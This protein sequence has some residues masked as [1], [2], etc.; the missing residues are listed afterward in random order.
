MPNINLSKDQYKVL[1]KMSEISSS[2]Y[3]ILGD[4]VSDN[5]KKQS[6]EIEK[7]NEY[8]LENAKNF[9]CEKFAEKYKGKY[10]PSDPFSKKIDSAIFE[11]DNETF[12]NELEIRLGK[13][14][15]EQSISSQ[16]AKEMKNNNGWY[17]ER[18]HLIYDKW[19]KEFEDYGI[20]RLDVVKNEK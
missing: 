17:P 9:G 18:I 19:Q 10:I 6:N 12:W 15:F 16:E 2:I 20:N 8:F 14:D 13:R 11:Y 5:Y 1:L 7:L 3:G 4:M